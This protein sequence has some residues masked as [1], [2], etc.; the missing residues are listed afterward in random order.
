MTKNLIVTVITS[1]LFLSLLSGTIYAIITYYQHINDRNS[2]I[3]QYNNAIITWIN[4]YNTLVFNH[5]LKVV[6]SFTDPLN[7]YYGPYEFCGQ[8]LTNLLD[9]EQKLDDISSYANLD[10]TQYISYYSRFRNQQHCYWKSLNSPNKLLINIS[11]YKPIHYQREL[12]VSDNNDE[13]STNSI[14]VSKK[15]V[16][17]LASPTSFISKST[18]ET[19]ESISFTDNGNKLSSSVNN[20]S[21]ILLSHTERLLQQSA[22]IT[23][24]PTPSSTSY[25]ISISYNY[26]PQINNNIYESVVNF[27]FPLDLMIIHTD[28]NGM[29][30]SQP[31]TSNSCSSNCLKFTCRNN[32][33]LNTTTNICEIWYILTEICII[34]DNNYKLI[35]GCVIINTGNDLI[36]D[37]TLS[38]I[39]DSSQAGIYRY[40]RR[41]GLKNDNSYNFNP[42]VTVRHI[43]DPYVTLLSVTTNTLQFENISPKLMNALG[44]TTLGCT[45]MVLIM[46]IRYRQRYYPKNKFSNYCCGKMLS[47]NSLERNNNNNSNDNSNTVR[48]QVLPGNTANRSTS[49][50]N[51]NINRESNPYY[52]S[53][54]R[55]RNNGVNDSSN[56]FGSGVSISNITVVPENE[57][58][59][60]DSDRN[61][62]YDINDSTGHRNIM[63]NGTRQP[64]ANGYEGYN[65][66]RNSRIRIPSRGGR[67]GRN[68][69]NNSIISS[70]TD[71]SNEPSII[72]PPVPP[73]QRSGSRSIN[74]RR[75]A[76]LTQAPIP[77]SY[78]TGNGSVNSRREVLPSRNRRVPGDNTNRGDDLG[79]EAETEEEDPQNEDPV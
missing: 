64:I 53:S 62:W 7:L 2:R 18:Q 52:Q 12:S 14:D 40:T 69:R 60:S 6:I 54:S 38:E 26:V 66:I 15:P 33:F 55:I 4:E 47:S 59:H 10:Y 42:M 78:R 41:M 24:S 31:C 21:S 45:I 58:N 25:P 49:T 56:Q 5:Y 9:H 70:V 44:Y 37:S 35:S 67:V 68:I 72:L 17:V 34:I 51:H 76:R 48:I 30:C 61:F 22:M 46:L 63:H 8:Q 32:G 74:G 3:N 73:L 77:P 71:P 23:P 50:T 28:I 57:D 43:D 65:N 20:P 79:N 39:V 1:L 16:A 29:Y 27:T 19:K 11:I 75:Q 13:L 36:L